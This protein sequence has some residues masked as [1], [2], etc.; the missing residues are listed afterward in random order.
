MLQHS[1]VK[2]LSLSH[3]LARHAISVINSLDV[4]TSGSSC[5]VVTAQSSVPHVPSAQCVG[6]RVICRVDTSTV[7]PLCP[8]CITLSTGPA[9]CLRRSPLSRP[10]AAH[11]K[12]VAH[13]DHST[14][15]APIESDGSVRGD[16]CGYLPITQLIQAHP[17]GAPVS[18]IM[19]VV[20][21]D[22]MVLHNGDTR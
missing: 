9:S 21:F 15:H 10:H 3:M 18:V 8:S 11:P 6:Y 5:S 4:H 22:R 7:L 17:P 20:H 2:F 19:Y 16:P 13:G 1:F 14:S 12:A